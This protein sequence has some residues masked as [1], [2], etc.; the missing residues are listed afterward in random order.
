MRVQAVFKSRDAMK[1]VKRRYHCAV[2]ERMVT[3]EDTVVT[4]LLGTGQMS[5]P[6]TASSTDIFE[7]LAAVGS[8]EG[9]SVRFKV[10]L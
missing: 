9:S 1:A 7:Y 6:K 8:I 3:Q 4:V 10:A 5:A 2:R